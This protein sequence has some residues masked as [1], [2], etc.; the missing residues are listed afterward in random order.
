MPFV[1]EVTTR[2]RSSD[3]YVKFS[4][5]HRVVLRMLNDHPKLVWKH[6]IPEANNGRGLMANC[7][8]TASQVNACPIEKS[9][10]GL[11]KDDPRTERR[12][13]KRYII[14]V[15]DRTP[16]GSCQSC[17][18]LTPKGKNCQSCGA[19]LKPS[20]DFAPIN[21]V[22]L[23]ESGPQLF[24]TTLMAVEKMQKEDYPDNEITDYDITFTTTGTGRERKIAAIPQAPSELP[25]DALN[26][27]ETGE[28]Q[29]LF[30]LEGALSEPNSVEEIEI[31]LAG[32]GI[33]ELN[34][35]RGIS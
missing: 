25:E 5:D 2:K 33:E 8:N 29:S 32:G 20:V 18:E 14:N 16:Y 4:P 24:S 28:P 21:R 23:L 31:M 34:A 1:D 19:T 35:V 12:A 30:D 17:N 11:P 26:D 6:W 15:L 9:L 27:P 3:S 7:P 22:K 10:K 13:R